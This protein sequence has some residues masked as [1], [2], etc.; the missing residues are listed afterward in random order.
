MLIVV[1][2][3]DELVALMVDEIIGELSTV[4]KPLGAMFVDVKGVSG[5]AVMPNGDVALILDIRSLIQM[6]KV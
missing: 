1:D 2:N 3:H 4:I 6:G 5:C